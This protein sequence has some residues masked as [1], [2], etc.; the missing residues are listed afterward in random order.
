MYKIL[1]STRVSNLNKSIDSA[2]VYKDVLK[3]LLK[4]ASYGYRDAY[5]TRLIQEIIYAIDHNLYSFDKETFRMVKGNILQ[6]LAES[7]NPKNR[8][9]LENLMYRI[10]VQYTKSSYY[11]RH[12]KIII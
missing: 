6:S 5:K 7:K 9:E 4:Y 12:L 3:G 11:P 10:Y 2:R 8:F 1:K